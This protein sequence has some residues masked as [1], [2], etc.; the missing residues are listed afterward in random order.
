MPTAQTTTALLDEIHDIFLTS[1]SVEVSSADEDL[2]QA[3]ILDSMVL[4]QLIVLLED[5]FGFTLPMEDLDLTAFRTTAGIA[6]I[7]ARRGNGL[8]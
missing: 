2:F 3:G 5:R 4:A 6:E 8:K 7:V 1:L